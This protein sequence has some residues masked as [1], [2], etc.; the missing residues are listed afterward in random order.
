M[1]LVLDF[2]LQEPY[3]L[4]PLGLVKKGHSSIELSI[5]TNEEHDYPFSYCLPYEP[6]NSLTQYSAF[7]HYKLRY[8]NKPLQT[9]LSLN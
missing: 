9:I 5:K 7:Y 6:V 2:W 1:G 4:K 3:K 8:N